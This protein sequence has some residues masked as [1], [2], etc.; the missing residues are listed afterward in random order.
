MLLNRAIMGLAND[1][2]ALTPQSRLPRRRELTAVVAQTIQNNQSAI[3]SLAAQ[4]DQLQLRMNALRTEFTNDYREKTNSM[5]DPFEVAR[6]EKG[7]SL[8]RA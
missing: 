3:I 4:L 7:V 2:E 5:R 8:L 1:N 6:E